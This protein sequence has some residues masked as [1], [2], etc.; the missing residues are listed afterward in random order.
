MSNPESLDTDKIYNFYDKYVKE[1]GIDAGWA[2]ESDAANAYNE[3]SNCPNQ[4]W[5][6]FQSVLDV[7]SGQGHLLPFLREERGFTGNYTGIEI[8]DFF[9]EKAISLYGEMPNARFMCDEF[10]SHDFSDKHFDWVVS[11]GSFSVKQPNQ[12]E[13]DRVFCRKMLELA[14]YGVSIF[15][16]DIHH[17]RPGRLEEVPDLAAHDIDKFVAMIQQTFKVSDVEVKHYPDE[18]AQPTMI[19][20][21]L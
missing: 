15:L 8:L 1:H 3:V 19:H 7:G 14:N 21:T 10:L 16:N 17:M 6:S 2:T 12:E 4:A 5:N 13:W 11:L 20:I 18:K 9:H